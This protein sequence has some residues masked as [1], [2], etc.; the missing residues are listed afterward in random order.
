MGGAP[1]GYHPIGQ[2][3]S[4]YAFCVLLD[5]L[6]EVCAVQASCSRQ[7]VYHRG[8]RSSKVNC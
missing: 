2:T 4:E 3:G 7:Q 8:G 6:T 1:R 5:R